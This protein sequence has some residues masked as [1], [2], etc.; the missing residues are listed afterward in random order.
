MV[1]VFIS[2]QL[3]S[4]WTC[5]L[6]VKSSP[7]AFVVFFSSFISI[8]CRFFLICCL[9]LWW[10]SAESILG[11]KY[12]IYYCL[13][14]CVILSS[15][16]CELTFRKKNKKKISFLLRWDYGIKVYVASFEFLLVIDSFLIKKRF[17]CVVSFTRL[18]TDYAI[19]SKENGK[20]GF[21]F[22][23]SS[24]CVMW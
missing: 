6:F 24:V 8:V 10:F 20:Y 7:L 13:S 14:F 22:H 17:I 16:T 4:S 5:V 18:S 21:L 15:S 1:F 9:L 11:R 23:L 12:V 2:F 3:L 19:E